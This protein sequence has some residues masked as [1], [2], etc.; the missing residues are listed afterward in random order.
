MLKR[1]LLIA[2]LSACLVI[3]AHQAYGFLPPAKSALGTAGEARALAETAPSPESEARWQAFVSSQGE[4]FTVTWNSVTRTPHRIQGRGI[5]V[6]SQVSEA[7]VAGL[8][9][10]FLHSKEALLGAD[11]AELRLISQEKHGA[12][13]YTDYQQ[14][15]RGLDVIGGRVSIRLTEQGIVTT[16][17]SD[18]YPD[19]TLATSPALSEAS[20]IVLAKQD[21]SFQEPGDK[22]LSSRLVILPQERGNEAIYYLAY[23]VRLRVQ[24]DPAA[25]R[26]P[27]LWRIYL[28]AN[29]GDV[30]RRQNEIYYDAVFGN[31]SGYIKPMYGT[32]PDQLQPFPDFYVDVAD[33]GTATTD[34]SGHYSLEAGTGGMRTISA[35]MAGRWAEIFNNNG[36][37]A[38]FRDSVAPGSEKDI[39]WASPASIASERNAYYHAQIVHGWAKRVDPTYTGMDR[40]TEI[41]VNQ[42]NYCNAYWDGNSIT[43]GAGSG[44]CQDLGLFADVLYHEY[45]HGIVDMQYRPLSPP[46]DMHEAF[47]DYT[48][49]TITNEPYIGEGLSG[50]GT[51]FRDLDNTLK[52]PDD[53]TGEVHD[54]GRI[55]GGALWDMREALAPDTHLAD[56]L[57]FY[58]RY[59][60]AGN[61]FDYFADILETDDDDGN[62]ANGTPH[63]YQIVQAFGK[64]GIG[65]GLYIDI[66]H[67]A[68]H[69]SEDSLAAYPVVATI[70]SNMTLD[71]DSLVLRYSAGGGFTTATMLP[72][73]NPNQYSATIPSQPYGTTV[74][75]YIYARAEGRTDYATS[76]AGAPGVLHIFSIG[77]DSSAPVITHTP[78]DDQPDAGWPATVTA[79]VTDNLGL[80]SVVLEYSKDGLPQTP[81]TMTQMPGTDQYA[82]QFPV[83][84]SA[85]DYIEY[86]IVATDASSAAHKTYSP[87]SGYNIFGISPASYYDFES[88]AQGWTHSAQGSWGDQWHVSAE[89]D[90]TSG[91]SQA[92][93]C[94][95]TG[96][97][98]YGTRLGALLDSPVVQL[99]GSTRLTFWY[100][101]DAED[102]VPLEGSGLAWDGAALSVID[103]TGKATS[104]TPVGGYPYRILAESGAPFTANKPV[105]SGHT[106]WRMATFDLSGF[107]GSY[108]IRIKF[109]SDEAVGFEGLYID[110]VTIWS[111]GALAGVAGGCDG[112][113]NPGLPARFAL[114]NVLPNPTQG[115]MNISYSV[116]APGS[117]VA[118][119]VFD[120]RGRLASTL[121][122]ESKT[123]G[124]YTAAWDGQDSNGNPVAPGIY[125][126][127]ME[128]RDF[129]ASSKVVLVR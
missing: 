113:V 49:C 37:E 8:V 70:T 42:P 46:G 57:F 93:K 76:P 40:Q 92:W 67:S 90:H 125:F 1:S 36:P 85:G 91:G 115:R 88:G 119:R 114:A 81:V 128:A 83:A 56:S 28:D 22:V 121:V 5:R 96:P 59:G 107:T 117:R 23:E 72:T 53:L 95:A 3:L 31:V 99:T 79:T 21:V 116:P 24:G 100:W 66:A 12:R 29:S 94:G 13:W 104:I 80:A 123:P 97:G 112:C 17:G 64:H 11:P 106:G 98:Q 43:I 48:A 39:L 45:G 69:D 109:G 33:Y 50:P 122:D 4:D 19:I 26:D 62:L 105:Y 55:L 75:Y 101:I 51:Y 73:G 82:A 77:I 63:Y 108:K 38:A 120:V 7:N 61:F 35:S 18:F 54:D 103:S 20:A 86:R 65:P 14:T 16:F 9:D 68:I 110:D 44:A 47:A 58:A 32:D 15:Y 127:R 2:S 27:A 34:A 10:S 87:A 126:I 6:A 74:S 102:Y 124:R 111:Q 30:L 25:G 78:L 41:F 60:K 89:R 84:A 71:P 129:S 52:Y 118:I